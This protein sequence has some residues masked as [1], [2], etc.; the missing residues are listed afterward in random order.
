MR[1]Q[2]LTPCPPSPT[3]D[4]ILTQHRLAL[5]AD[6]AG[7]RNHAHRVLHLCRHLDPALDVEKVA[8]A[9]AFHDLG[10]WTHRTFDYLMPS[11]DLAAAYLR[12]NGQAGWTQEITRAIGD[13]H[14]LSRSESGA[15]SLAEPFRRADWIDVTMGIVSFGVTRSALRQ[16]YEPWPSAGFHWRL[17]QLS[18]RRF[19]EHPL[20]PLP[21][22]KR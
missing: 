14:K 7:Y 22:V 17:V 20:N 4:A 11:A 18:A 2:D 21:M 9:A 13:H 3:V 10:I 8:I 15:G 6:Y 16:I 19:R 1:I 5:G 12:Q